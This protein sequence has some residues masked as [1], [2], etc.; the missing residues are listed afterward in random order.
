M[1]M[2]LRVHQDDAVLIEQALVAFNEHHETIA[3]VLCDMVMP[4]L[5]GRATI[6]AI[7]KIDRDARIIAMSGLASNRQSPAKRPTGISAF[8]PKPYTASALLQTI[9]SVI[10]GRS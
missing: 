10:A 1:S 2:F 6:Q 4:Y 9:R 3:L 8:L 5:D 7:Q